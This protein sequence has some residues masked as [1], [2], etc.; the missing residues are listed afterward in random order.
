MIIWCFK[1]NKNAQKFYHELGGNIIKEKKVV[2]GDEEY[3]E[4][5]FYFDLDYLNE[6]PF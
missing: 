1:E 6:F 2:L 5:C 3:E 4:V